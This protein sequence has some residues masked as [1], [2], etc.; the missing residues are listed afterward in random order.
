MRQNRMTKKHEHIA[1]PQ[2]AGRTTG[3][4]ASEECSNRTEAIALY[5]SACQRL[6]DVNHW[7]EH[8]G[9]SVLSAKFQ[10]TDPNGNP[11]DRK[12]QEGDFIRIDLP[13]PGLESGDGYDWVQIE[14]LQESDTK[15]ESDYDFCAIRVRPA[16]NPTDNSDETAHFYTELASSTFTVSREGNEVIAKETG[17]NEI[18]NNKD[19]EEVK[20][21][22]RNTFI[23]ETASRG[24]AWPQWKVLME[25]L[26]KQEKHEE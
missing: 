24:L 9:E 15:F 12:P 20:D 10:L 18:P 5:R 2:I 4:T 11:V 21:T 6:F 26:L 22:V 19:N 17:R 14:S 7:Y 25:G 1:P 13:A 23:A 8:T 16:P 3:A